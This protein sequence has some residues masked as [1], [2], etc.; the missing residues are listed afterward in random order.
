M[1]LKY[2]IFIVVFVLSAAFIFFFGWIQIKLPVNTYGVAFT[3]SG[4]YLDKVYEPGK[5]SWDFRKLIPGNFRLLKFE[6]KT[7]QLN[8]NYQGDLPSGKT[9]SEYLPNSPDFSFKFNYLLSYGIR[10]K[11]LPDMVDKY[12]LTPDQITIRYNAIDAELQSFITS[13]YIEKQRLSD[14]VGIPYDNNKET[15]EE[16]KKVLS[17]QF[18]DLEIYE[19]IAYEISLPDI[20]LYNKGRDIYLHSLDNE[21]RIISESRTKIA[22]QEIRD[23]AN[24]ET[25]KKYGELLTEYPAL[26]DFFSVIEINCDSII[27]KVNIDLP[28]DQEPGDETN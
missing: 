17:G 13:F 2:I 25:L 22:E 7:R 12:K 21:N 10:P 28:V 3:K 5:F 9:Y 8:I 4:G 6:L 26:I 14:S 11:K 27:P 23:A 1:K 24:F 16:V 18:P 15:T 19:Y 20:R